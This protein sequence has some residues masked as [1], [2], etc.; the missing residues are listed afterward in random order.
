MRLPPAQVRGMLTGSSLQRQRL[1]SRKAG[2]I[3]FEAGEVK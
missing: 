3:E 2:S 1:T